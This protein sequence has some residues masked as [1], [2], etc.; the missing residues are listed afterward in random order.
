MKIRSPQFKGII[1]ITAL[2]FFSKGLGFGRELLI[3]SLFGVSKY[4]D[5]FVL[6]QN[7]FNVFAPLIAD[8]GQTLTTPL[9]SRL[10]KSDP[11]RR[12]IVASALLWTL[13]AAGLIAL[14]IGV[15][16]HSFLHVIA[17]GLSTETKGIVTQYYWLLLPFGFLTALSGV[18][19]ASLNSQERFG[20]SESVMLSMNL[21]GLLGLVWLARDHQ[22]YALPVSLSVGALSSMCLYLMLVRPSLRGRFNEPAMTRQFRILPPLLSGYL[23]VQV[24]IL[25][26]RHFASSLQEG[27]IA[28]INYANKVVFLPLSVVVSG[29]IAIAF[30]RFAQITDSRAAQRLLAKM[31]VA[32][33]ALLLPLTL[34]LTLCAPWVVRLLF[35]RGAFDVAAVEMTSLALRVLALALIPLGVAQLLQKYLYA[36]GLANIVFIASFVSVCT[37]VAANVLLVPR[38]GMSGLL[39]SIVIANIILVVILIFGIAAHDRGRSEPAPTT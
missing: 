22:A 30:V 12:S 25:V 38:V 28:A 31:G 17:P 26:D 24:N 5:A 23:L 16:I 32:I 27:S 36:R 9:L 37:G 39:W 10:Q 3:A 4:V 6:A 20:A 2:Q 7:V 13:A 18:L 29:V 15:S 1:Y 11:S 19:G 34:L 14:L 8:A 21:V 33:T 35:F